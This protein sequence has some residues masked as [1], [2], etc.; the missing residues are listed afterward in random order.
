MEVK[1]LEEVGKPFSTEMFVLEE[2]GFSSFVQTECSTVQAPCRSH[3]S[4]QA[5]GSS[6]ERRECR[7]SWLPWTELQA[8]GPGP[9]RRKKRHNSMLSG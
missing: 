9:Y 6:G 2:Q 7:G 8:P 4:G 3:T 1:G 5:A